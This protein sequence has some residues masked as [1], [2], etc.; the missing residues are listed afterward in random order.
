MSL[1][2]LPS[3]IGAIGTVCAP[4][5]ALVVLFSEVRERRRRQASQVAAWL[6]RAE[7]EVVLHVSNASQNPIYDVTITPQLLGCDY[8][9]I[10]Y[11]LIGPQTAD[12]PLRIQLPGCRE[13]SNRYLGTQICFSDSAGRRWRRA[14]DGSLHYRLR[15]RRG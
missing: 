2:D 14:A 4:A 11:Q 5:V 8:D 10:Q 9:K 13:I 1:G 7:T 3:W 15:R 6:V 12:V